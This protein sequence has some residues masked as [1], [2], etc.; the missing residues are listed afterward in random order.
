MT[1]PHI[2]IIGGGASGVLLAAHLLRDPD[3]DIRITLIEKRGEVGRGVAYS[4][5]QQDHVL[6]VAAP[7]MSAF[8]DDPDH[9][10][11][12]LLGRGLVSEA[13]RFVF[14]PR[15][16]YGEY[17][18]EVLGKHIDDGRLQLLHDT[19]VAVHPSATGVELTLESGTSVVGH[20]A[21]LAVGHEERAARA[22]GIAV[23]VGSEEDTPL[24]PDADV[25]I[26]GSGL[27]MVDA[28]LTLSQSEHRGPVTVVSRHGL[29]PKSHRDVEKMELEAADV[30]FGTELHYFA[31]WFRETVDEHVGRGGNWR[32][33]VDALRPF[34]QRIWQDW[35]THSRRRFLEHV[36]PFWNI[37]RHRLPP[38]LYDRMRAAVDAGQ[39]RLVAGKVLDI[40]RAG[41]RVQAR[42]RVK[43]SDS[44]QAIEVARVYD[45]GGVS[46]DVLQSSNPAVQSLITSGAARPD[47][48]HIG[49]DVTRDCAVLDAGGVA[50]T[51]LFA[52]GPLT[53]GTFFEIEAIPD[54][55][56]QVAGLAGRLVGH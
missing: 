48:L 44:D 17:L 22:K 24:D 54:I 51:R 31:D 27:S 26:L 40:D 2:L 55:R 5:R 29:L 39:V 37:H 14:M 19:V 45:C 4:A 28:W 7:G 21:V 49:L 15:R 25:M 43:G 20:S 11:R 8:A 56:M 12:W 10:W 33:A 41:D 1:R 42:V 23:R 35:S 13:N 16:L 3:A 9:F 30:P 50:S 52:V 18:S 6:N 34:N 36:R 46:V 47:E 38:D 53:R 32:G